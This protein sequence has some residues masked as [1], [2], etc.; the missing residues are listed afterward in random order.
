MKKYETSAAP[1][2]I[3][4][5][6]LEE[7]LGLWEQTDAAPMTPELPTVRGWLMDELERRNPDGFN[8]WMEQESPEDSQLRQY[9][10]INSMCLTCSKLRISCQGTTCQTWTGCIYKTSKREAAQKIVRL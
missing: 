8:V 4:S 1:A 5:A 10:T 9:M 6:S 2:R 3:T 7:L